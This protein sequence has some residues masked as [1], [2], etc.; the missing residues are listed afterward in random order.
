MK[1]WWIDLELVDDLVLSRRSASQ[2]DHECLDRVPGTTLRGWCAAHLYDALGERAWAVFHGG[3][4]RWLDGLPA[5]AQGARSVPAPLSWHTNKADPDAQAQRDGA[6]QP[7]HLYNLAA[8][9][10][11]GRQAA[12]GFQPKGLR[13]GYVGAGGQALHAERRYRLM[14]AIERDGQVAEGQLFGYES[15]RA[16]QRF[17]AGLEIDEGVADA[18]LTARLLA[19]LDGQLRLGRSRSA[20]YGRVR[21]RPRPAALPPAVSPAE[22]GSTVY[23]LLVSDA[24][25]RDAH[26]RPTL[27]PDAGVLGLPA[28]VSIE[29]GRSFLRSRRYS[30]WNAYRGGPELERQTLAAGGVLTLH[31]PQ[32]FDAATLARLARGISSERALGLGE[33]LLHP[34]WLR[35]PQPQFDDAPA[36]AAPQPGA[37]AAP[38][39]PPPTPLLRTLAQRAG[40]ARR[41]AG[42]DDVTAEALRRLAERWLALRRY[43]AVPADEEWGPGASQWG[44][45]AQAGARATTLA[46]LRED[47]LGSSGI[48]SRRAD[49]HDAKV[50]V[51]EYWDATAPAA[52]GEQHSL[53][54]WV[55]ETLDE[56]ARHGDA[57]APRLDAWQ[58]LCD[59]VRRR[60]WHL[61]AAALASRA[62]PKEGS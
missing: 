18:D 11:E 62:A 7:Q 9:P 2:G 43:L 59:T 26:G 32:G 6:W 37:G 44:A 8:G 20:Q 45:L 36:S 46:Q 49:K 33:V 12:I 5:D 48:V 14:T 25:L 50:K 4:V 35:G 47:L 38:Q 27:A 22:A 40:A 13:A 56:L 39:A 52:N 34:G 61:N 51:K 41:S 53:A 54:H 58:R 1:R 19:A 28:D 15:L 31:S 16:G 57:D 42:L 29:R 10:P 55:G 23:L 3:G 24:C 60:Q 30:G 17:V 21:A